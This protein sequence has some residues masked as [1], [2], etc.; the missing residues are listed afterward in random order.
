MRPCFNVDA[1]ARMCAFAASKLPVVRKRP[2][3]EMNTSRPQHRAQPA[4]KWGSPAANE[5]VDTA[6]SSDADFT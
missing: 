5:G 3:R 6:G 1:K 2:R 4:E